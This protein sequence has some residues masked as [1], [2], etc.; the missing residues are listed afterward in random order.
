MFL[1][2]KK[3]SMKILQILLALSLTVF[4]TA[5]GGGNSSST[6]KVHP[7]VDA[8]ENISVETLENVTLS[9]YAKDSDGQVTNYTWEQTF[10]T[11]VKLSDL[12]KPNVSFVSP[13]INISEILTFG[14]NNK[15]DNLQSG[16]AL[17]IIDTNN[18][19][20]DINET[21]S[22]VVKDQVV[23]YTSTGTIK[24][25][26][27]KNMTIPVILSNQYGEPILVGRKIKGSD[28]AEI[29]LESTAEMFLLR[30]SKFFGITITDEQELSRRIKAHPYFSKLVEEL[31][32]RISL[33]PC[34]L[35]HQCSAIASM[36]VDKI[37]NEIEFEDLVEGL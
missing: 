31:N 18:I 6:N 15:D 7:T 16:E 1:I 26:G 23:P 37:V 5:C 36:Y 13:D 2:H 19:D 30:S 32:V 21:F 12:D 17:V 9:S 11:E 29:S 28:K 22:I 8:G 24:F 10:G 4:L 25:I 33:S 14:G 27:E 20:I 3:I 34:P 35:D